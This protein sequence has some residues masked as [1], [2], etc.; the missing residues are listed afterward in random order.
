MLKEETVVKHVPNVIVVYLALNV[1]KF[2]H[3]TKDDLSF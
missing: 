3:F 2:V 1:H